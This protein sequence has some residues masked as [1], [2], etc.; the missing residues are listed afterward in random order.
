MK[1]L[2]ILILFFISVTGV[3][4]R[5]DIH[6][7]VQVPKSV[8]AGERFEIVFSLRN[9]S[10]ENFKSPKFR[11]CKVLSGPSISRSSQLAVISG[12]FVRSVSENRSYILQAG[13]KG[14]V[15][16][17]SVSVSVE[18]KTYKSRKTTIEI[19]SVRSEKKK[20]A[21]V[22]FISSVPEEVRSGETFRVRYQVI[23]GDGEDFNT[24]DF[25]NC[26]VLAGPSITLER[27]PILMN[28]WP[29]QGRIIT[30]YTYIVQAGESGK[31]IIPEAKILVNNKKYKVGKSEVKIR[32][33][34][35]EERMKRFLEAEK[36]YPTI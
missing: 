35:E 10:T 4:A 19:I 8:Q 24:G 21:S 7:D 3:Y 31:V 15:V 36:K 16:I 28:G 14:T 5:E 29:I 26:K 18:G 25:K 6:L 22:Q 33:L 27:E 13:K 1:K 20:Q 30:T 12:L 11:G 34:N 2:S 23:N 17:P 32:P 9:A